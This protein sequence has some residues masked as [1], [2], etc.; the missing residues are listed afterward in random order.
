MADDSQAQTYAISKRYRLILRLSLASFLVLGV[1]FIGLLWL[2]EDG[3]LPDDPGPYVVV[4]VGSGLFLGLAAASFQTL[5][6][7]PRCA[8]TV[9][10]DGLWPARRRKDEALV[11]WDAIADVRQHP[12]RDFLELLDE[13]GDRLLRLEYQLDGFADLRRRVLRHLRDVVAVDPPER[14]AR[15]PIYHIFQYG[16]MAALVVGGGFLASHNVWLA[17]IP[18]G[19]AA[20]LAGAYVRGLTGLTLDRDAV[21]LHYPFTSRTVPYEDVED[22]ALA[23]RRGRGTVESVVRVTFT[24]GRNA[25]TLAG[26]G[27]DNTILYEKFRQAL[28]ARGRGAETAAEA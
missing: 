24:D 28:E 10:G 18:L 11:P 16:L 6:R 26:L 21:T 3:N 23:E 14:F 1:G 19:L 27:V 22:V 8:V 25:L 5:K 15:K 12:A 4:A 9:D 20:I 17:M 2:P 7:L 13:R